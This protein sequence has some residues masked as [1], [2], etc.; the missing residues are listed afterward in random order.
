MVGG[1]SSD[2]DVIPF[3]TML[4]IFGKQINLQ[5][6]VRSDYCHDLFINGLI[7]RDEERNKNSD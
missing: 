6:G 5:R 1:E 3:G 4:F 2:G 7:V